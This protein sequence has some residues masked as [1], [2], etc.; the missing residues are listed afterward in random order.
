ME[1]KLDAIRGGIPVIESELDLGDLLDLI[2]VLISPVRKPER[3]ANDLPEWP[4]L[5]TG[6]RR[7]RGA[8]ADAAL[9]TREQHARDTAARIARS[10]DAR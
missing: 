1:E 6:R 7:P 5:V 10:L 9:A 3:A 8:R 2:E 4:R